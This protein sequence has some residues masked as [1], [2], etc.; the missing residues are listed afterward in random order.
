TY[1]L[2]GV[3]ESSANA[4]SQP[5]TG[6]AAVTVNPLPTASISGTT[7][8]CLNAPSPN[9]TFTGAVGTPPFTFTYTINGG[10]NQTVTTTSG[11]SVTVAA[12][13]NVA[14]TFTY[15]LVSVQEGSTITCSQ[16]QTG[17]ATITVNQLP[18]ATIA[19]TVNVCVNATSPNITFTGAVGTPPYTFTYNIN[20]GANLTIT[21]T[22]GNSVTVAVPTTTAGTY[23]YN[24]V[25]VQEGSGLQCSQTQSGT[26]TV[27]VNPLPTAAI[28]GATEVCRNAPSPNITFTGAGGTAPYTFTYTIN[29][30]PNQTVTTTTGNTVTV[31]VPTA[32]A[33]TFTYN[34]VSVQDAS[35]TL[36]SQ[37]QTGSVAVI[38][39]PLPVSNFTTN[40]PT[41]AT[42]TISFT[43]VSVPNAG[44]IVSWQ[45]NFDDP[46]SGPLNTSTQQNP[47][48]IFGAAGTYNVSLVVTTDK[49]CVSTTPPQQVVIRPRPLAGYIIPEVCLSDTYAQFTDTSSV[50]PPDFIQGW[51]WNFGDPVSGPLNT[52]TVQNPQH[53]YTSTGSYNVQLIATSNAGCKDTVSHTLFVNGS[54]PTA[55]FIVQN[56]S[57]LCAN[58]SVAITEAST[59]FPGSITKVEIY[60]DNVNQPTVFDTDNFPF[61]GKVYKHL[62]PN[63]QA[64]PTR[65][66]TIRYRAYSGGVCVN[67]KI[68][69]IT[70]NAAPLVQFSLMPDICYDAAPVSLLPFISF[71]G[72]PGTGTFSGPGVTPAGIFTPSSVNPGNTYTIQYL[73]TSTAAGCRDSATQTIR[74]IDTAAARFTV[75]NLACERSPVDFS[76][77]SSTIPA[78]SGTITGW[79]WNFGDPTS[80]AANTSTLQNPSHLFTS[81]GTYTVTL[82]VT[83]SNGCRSTVYSAPVVVNPIPRPNFTFPVSSCL[84]SA[85]VQ[86][87][88]TSGI[89]GGSAS[90][91]TYLWNFGDPGSGPLNTSS[92]SSPSH[93]Y[94]AVGP[95]T[96]NLLATSSAGCTR[97]TNIILNSVHPQPTGSF[98]VNKPDVCVGQSFQFTDNSNPADGTTTQW[99]WNLGDG[100]V[101]TTPA[102]SYTYGSAGSY[103]VSL[104]IIN[105]FGCRST[106]ATQDLTVNPYPVVDAGPNLFILEGGSDTL[107]PIVSAINPTFLW[108]PNQYFLSSNAIE[109]PIVKGVDDIWY[110]LT[111]TGRGGC[112]QSDRVFIKV[113][114]GPEIPNIFSPN[115]DGVH[116]TWVIKYLDTYPGCTVEIFNRYGQKIFASTGYGKPW[117]G[118]VNGKPVPVGTYYYIVNP[119]NGRNIM[120]GYVDVIR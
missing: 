10:P 29:G 98:T 31:A 67:D 62:Y 63:F 87:T 9:I 66:Y 53:S 105:N 91:M 107:Q 71:G 23:N 39:N 99:N 8:V 16:A 100:N 18:T 101:R 80:G 35:S 45:W 109:R 104:Y 60:W 41:C 27:V 76:S 79:N 92:G 64:P 118:T 12:P 47:T 85:N 96:V 103:T 24:L 89:P 11:N 115:G 83:T 4:C 75:T 5:Q 21:T 3:S 33:G 69:T 44:A 19:G 110:T 114:K 6:S 82:Q 78:N 50:S 54:F 112:Q 93:I 102:F 74:V 1:N 52:S 55:N 90:S 37:A 106:T 40:A 59:V 88:N 120:T 94:N 32:T 43:D 65:N 72:V 84:P 58:D 48:H 61:S 2:V 42:R 51:N 30:G 15:N 38:V 97:D 117:D 108:T 28:S 70:I 68:Q 113:L 17:S 25:S 49:G 56:A 95:Y 86:F 13:T 7:T 116:D 81:W 36:C 22:S 34:L 73:H 119:K 77:L 20:G 26:A 111:V 57:T 14:G 46:A